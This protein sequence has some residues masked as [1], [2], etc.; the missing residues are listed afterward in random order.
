MTIWNRILLVLLALLL[1]GICRAQF[2]DPFEGEKISGWFCLTGDG[3]AKMEFIQK[4][5]YAQMVIDATTDRYNVYWTLIKRNV[6][7]FLDL[8]KFKDTTYQ[9]RVEA[10]VRLHDAPRRLNFMVNTQRTTN[11]HEDLM[12]FDIPDTNAWHVISMTTKKFDVLPGDSVY[13]QLA[14]TDYGIGKFYVDVDYYKAEIV[15]VPTA[16]PDKGTAVPY[17]PPVP[18]IS[19]FQ[20]HL[21]VSQDG[22]INSVFPD[23]NFNDWCVKEK[24][25]ISR[26]ITVNENQWAILNWDFEKYKNYPLDKSGVLELTTQSVSKGGQYE[27]AFGKDLGMEFGKVRIIEIIG[28]DPNWNQKNVTYN[29][30][31]QNSE[32]GE[33]FNL[34]MLFDTEVCDERGCKNYITISKPVLQRLIEGKTKGLLIRPLG[35]INTSFYS[36]E[37]KMQNSGP[38][39]HF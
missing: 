10:R 34:Q 37:N 13:V 22:L 23:V 3:D 35:A 21:V 1:S 15:H 7:S 30:F 32:Y 4:N 17:H 9:L 8:N 24:D 31:M 2:H 33:V 5:G 36:S 28:G 18:Q 12:E 19:T 26:I 29:N 25:S 38:V 11:Y 27:L 14:A 39:L 6:A 20:N 16:T